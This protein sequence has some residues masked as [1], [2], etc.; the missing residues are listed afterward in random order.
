[1]NPWLRAACWGLLLGVV[2]F[3]SQGLRWPWGNRQGWS[4]AGDLGFWF[5]T[6]VA[7]VAAAAICVVFDLRPDRK[8]PPPAIAWAFAGFLFFYVVWA[9]LYPW[10][11]TFEVAARP[12]WDNTPTLVALPPNEKADRA[13]VML[14]L[15]HEDREEI[16]YWQDKLFTVSFWF[17]AAIL[18][19]VGFAVQRDTLN[20]SARYVFPAAC[21]SLGIFYLIFARYAGGAISVN[22]N[23][24]IGIQ[25]ALGLS[26]QDYY[27]KGQRVY[28]EVRELMPHPH[29]AHLVHLNAL[30]VIGSVLWLVFFPLQRGGDSSP[31]TG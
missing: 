14:H 31:N 13:S 28:G 1:M 24:L 5:E 7:V 27:L 26:E 20:P 30:F 9:A 12:K 3:L 17:N 4:A 19:I 23:D 10:R 18:G 15:L 2:K 29:I 6:I 25:Y 8:N 16:R 21:L 11:G 22:D